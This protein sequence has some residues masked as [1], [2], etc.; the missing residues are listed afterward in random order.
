[1]G[2]DITA[3]KRLGVVENPEID[4]DG[5]LENYETE[6]TPGISMKWSETYFL[7]R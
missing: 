6:W 4:E 2:L 1:M 5:Y 3:Y 7:C